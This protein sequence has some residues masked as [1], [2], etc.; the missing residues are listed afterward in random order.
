[1]IDLTKSTDHANDHPHDPGKA[2]ADLAAAS[3]PGQLKPGDDLEERQDQLLDEA[4]EETFPA[5][6]P[7]SPK[8]ITK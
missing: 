2:K 8:R 5:S 1:M 6:D 4:V 3:A 7:I